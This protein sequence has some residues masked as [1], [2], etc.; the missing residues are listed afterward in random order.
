MASDSGVRSDPTPPAVLPQPVTEDAPVT[1]EA[2]HATSGISARAHLGALAVLGGVVAAMAIALPPFFDTPMFDDWSFIPITMGF[3]KTGVLHYLHNNDP[4]LVS[5]MVLGGL[6]LRVVGASVSNLRV[7]TLLLSVVAAYASFGVLSEL[8]LG[9]RRSLL[10]ALVLV[11]NPIYAYCSFTWMTDVPALALG[12]LALWAFLAGLRRG[13]LVVWVGAALALTAALSR[14]TAL[15]VPLGVLVY[16][17]WRRRR[18]PLSLWLSCILPIVLGFVGLQLAKHIPDFQ[19]HSLP[20][21]SLRKQYATLPATVFQG[22]AF[23]A[24]SLLPLGAA[25]ALGV[26]RAVLRAPSRWLVAGV[27][28]FLFLVGLVAPAPGLGVSPLAQVDVGALLVSATFPLEDLV[29]GFLIGNGGPLVPAAVLDAVAWLSLLWLVVMLAVGLD[30]L[31][32]SRLASRVALAP[33]GPRLGVV[34][35]GVLVVGVAVLLAGLPAWTTLAERAVRMAHARGHCRELGLEHWLGTARQLARQAAVVGALFL[36]FALSEL[37]WQAAWRRGAWSEGRRAAGRVVWGFAEFAVLAMAVGAIGGAIAAVVLKLLWRWKIGGDERPKPAPAATCDDRWK[38]V[39]VRAGVL[40]VFLVLVLS[41]WNV[42]TRHFLPVV[43]PAA[44]LVI[45]AAGGARP[46]LGA[47]GAIALVFLAYGL[48]C[49]SVYAAQLEATARVRD[50]LIAQGYPPKEIRAGLE[51]DGLHWRRYSLDHPEEGK[52]RLAGGW[53]IAL[54]P[55]LH[56]TYLVA[57]GLECYSMDISG[58]EVMRKE[59]FRPRLWPWQRPIYVLRRGPQQ[60]PASGPEGA[61]R[62]PGG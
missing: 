37:G 27:C 11:V 7:L 21:P 39:L 58:Y 38:V 41:R 43:I 53:P 13:G 56:D 8:G 59:T 34:L 33:R 5:Q 57:G 4:C 36:A 62:T 40:V 25:Y 1:A 51:L 50:E 60:R 24:F 32:G 44:L 46:S 12:Q 14:Q 47:F 10:G 29:Q 35:G 23:V 16:L 2:T 54:T 15:A 49:T 42:W 19:S 26:W 48:V 30:R 52:A 17:M 45:A 22:L 20:T 18:A 9:W 31:R 28:C 3:A 61:P 6:W 55:V